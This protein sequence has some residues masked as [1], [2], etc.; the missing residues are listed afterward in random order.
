M[1][2]E[3]IKD[4]TK[5]DELLYELTNLKKHSNELA[6]N[7]R[8]EKLENYIDNLSKN[9]NSLENKVET[10]YEENFKNIES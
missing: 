10:I 7:T 9:I 1:N 8:G 4:K 6:S 2:D 5:L 3:L